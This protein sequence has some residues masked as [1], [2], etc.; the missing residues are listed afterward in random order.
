[1][2]EPLSHLAADDYVP[3]LDWS[4]LGWGLENHTENTRKYIEAT[5]FEKAVAKSPASFTQREAKALQPT[6][7]AKWEKFQKDRGYEE[8]SADLSIIDEYYYGRRFH[9]RPQATG[10]CTVS[11]TFRMATR[12]I[13]WEILAKGQ[14]EETLGNTEYGPD[15]VSFYAPL[16]YGIARQLGGLR[17]G[18]GGFCD[19]TIESL[20]MGVLDCNNGKL[21]EILHS[22]GADSEND[23]PEPSSTA[24]YRKFQNWTYNDTLKPFLET[25]LVESVKCTNTDKLVE[26]LR[27]YKPAIMCSMLAVKK[28]GTHQG[29]TYF[30]ADRNNQWAHNMCW[31]GIIVW[32]GRTFLLLSNE[33]WQDNLIYPI[34]IEEVQDVIFPRYR[35]EVQTLGEFDLKDSQIEA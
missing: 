11:N 32:H 24:V 16:S 18:D 25:P 13:L 29:M 15:T 23:Y 30:I 6:F 7:A 20:M 3:E 34:P 21:N 8:G 22:L 10:S 31:A 1:M 26:N 4:K 14:L 33:S 27:Q 5:L 9:W 2:A 17:S 12:R 28:G 35:P 19:T